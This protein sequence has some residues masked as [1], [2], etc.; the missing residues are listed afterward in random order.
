MHLS[1]KIRGV[2]GH[3]G[4]GKT[5]WLANSAAK[6]QRVLVL[7]GFKEKNEYDTQRIENFTALV[8]FFF[9]KPPRFRVSYY[10][11]PCYRPC[12]KGKQSE[13]RH[14]CE[15]VWAVG[16]NL[17]FVIEE[18]ASYFPKRIVPQEFMF[19]AT[20][21]RHRQIDMDLSAQAP[22]YLPIEIRREMDELVCFHLSEDN[23][24]EWVEGFPGAENIGADIK[25]LPR[26]HYR[27][28]FKEPPAIVRGRIEFRGERKTAE[29]AALPTVQQP[30]DPS[31]RAADIERS[32]PDQSRDSDG[33]AGKGRV[34][35]L[36][37]PGGSGNL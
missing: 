22:Y 29:A 26:L 15:L 24:I 23:D 37:D 9:R 31:D 27:H 6:A 36:R 20:K 8:K 30:E 3:S 18:A 33:A 21:G 13:F 11:L 34:P 5:V 4:Y 35:V 32:E 19:L 1:R 16:G 25:A 17:R 28:V 12:C 2:L 10:P 7:E 14:V